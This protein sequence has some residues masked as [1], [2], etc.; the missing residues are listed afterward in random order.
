[1][2]ESIVRKLLHE[3]AL[4]H[5]ERLLKI[6][7]T[8][9][10][11]KCK[12]GETG[13]DY[14]DKRIAICELKEVA[15]CIDGKD[16]EKLVNELIKFIDSPDAVVRVSVKKSLRILLQKKLSEDL[17]KRIKPLLKS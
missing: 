9:Q 3:P 1:M 13:I 15:K 5:F 7:N 10:K 2:A 12:D 6:I 4:K 16:A 11:K 17:I 8:P 14:F